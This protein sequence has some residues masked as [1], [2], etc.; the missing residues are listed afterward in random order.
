MNHN[1]EGAVQP[2]NV[3][4]ALL[5]SILSPLVSR[6][7]V[8]NNSEMTIKSYRRSVEKLVKF[9]HY[10]EPKDMDMDQV[11]DFL[12]FLK[13]ENHIQWSTSKMYVAGLRYYWTHILDD[14][15]FAS[16]IPYPREKPSFPKVLSREELATLFDGCKSHKHRTIFRLM[17]GS[18]LRRSELLNLKIEDIDTK[19]NKNRIRVN[20]GKGDKDRYVVLPLNVLPDL[21][22]YYTQCKPKVYLFNGRIK[23][24]KMS[25]GGLR[26]ALIA[27]IK[28][29]GITKSVN[30][31]I[32]RHSYATHSLEH[33]MHIK[34]LQQLLGHSSITTTLI[35]LHISE[36]PLY[37]PFSPLDKWENVDKK[38]E[39]ENDKDSDQK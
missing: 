32:F 27:A 11:I 18:G 19:D 31:H 33:G 14:Q 15:E 12:C 21:R 3:Q 29:S 28:K 2:T 4:N 35:Y 37:P 10:L 6:L 38:K 9:H 34:M 24:E 22:T 30:L 20:K 25:E 16:R 13:E 17:Y 36:L 26:H 5:V 7:R 39:N 1:D 23:G 8:A